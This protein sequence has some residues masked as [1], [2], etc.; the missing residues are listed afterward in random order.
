MS[1]LLSAQSI[2][3][4]V[5]SGPLL[6]G[7]SFTLTKG[8]RIGLVGHNG[9]GKST[10]LKLLTNTLTGYS[11]QI[12]YAS[13]CLIE[14]VEQHLP[15]ELHTVSMLDA[16]AARL[17]ETMRLAE[18]WQVEL[19]LSD[20][21]FTEQDWTLTAG[22]LSGGQ[23]TRLLLAR[24]LIKQP[25]VLLLD[26]P[27]NHMDL[28]TL[29]WLESFLL[30][31]KGSFIL[32][33]HDQRLLDTVTNCTWIMRDK[34]L[35]FFR[36][37][38]S[39][40]R[41]ALEEKDQADEQRHQAEQKE[42]NR[43]EK[44][45]KRLAVWGKVYDNE[46]LARKAK[47]MEKRADRL[48][49]SQTQLTAGAPWQLALK[50]ESL[51]ANRLLELSALDVRPE[52]SA[53][54]LFHVLAKQLKSGD[55]AAIM[56]RNGTGKSSLLRMLWQEFQHHADLS[57]A[58]GPIVFH[59]QGRL[60]YYDQTLQQLNDNDTLLEALRHFAPLPDEQ[61]KMALISAG[62]PYL[63][64]SQ[65]V[66]GLSGG[67]RSRLLFIGLTLAKHHLLFLDEPTNH[68]DLEG[69]E[70]LASTLSQF[71][72]GCILVSHDRELIEKSCNRFWLVDDQ[73][74]EEWHDLDLIYEKLSGHHGKSQTQ[75]E[76]AEADSTEHTDQERLL[77][78]LI[79]LEML[80][81]EDLARKQKHQKPKL[82]QTWKSE[83]AQLS[84]TL[85]LG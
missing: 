2:F 37:P 25:D 60:G 76:S 19:L 28:P 36:L 3:Y 53:P 9:C 14:R 47:H 69:K 64:H 44:S 83:I 73:Q 26:E 68:L 74:L 24:A 22:T 32:V 56:G 43:I 59:P 13:Q 33:S 21:G 16:V 10:L 80:L 34:T 72:G 11:G 52:P 20:M 85:E 67:E 41:Q 75:A 5:T 71:E 35:Q 42:I 38:C 57:A 61:R 8:D 31:W 77:A 50:G 65:T 40:A 17:P 66:A 46:D 4:D 78:R 70:E 6:E 82:Q 79:E 55:R 15:A 49:D 63:R 29:L 7:I 58:K 81:E 18:L 45:A 1:T 48:K 27:S 51:P 39:L 84:D 62:F 54:I 12:T 23:H 30:N